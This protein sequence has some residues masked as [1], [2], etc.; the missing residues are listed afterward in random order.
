MNEA[1]SSKPEARRSR[2]PLALYLLA[3]AEQSTPEVGPWTVADD[4]E[5]LFRV[6]LTGK[7]GVVAVRA[8][9]RLSGC[10]IESDPS[11]Q[12]SEKL[13]EQIRYSLAGVYCVGER[14]LTWHNQQKL[15][16]ETPPGGEDR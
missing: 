7:N 15:G 13:E 14:Q 12:W 8:S 4:P 16:A 9:Q 5:D 2:S 6:V 3:V 1:R 10:E 11:G